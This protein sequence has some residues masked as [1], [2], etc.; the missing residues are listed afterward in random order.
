[1][2]I[3]AEATKGFTSHPPTH[4]RLKP[5]DFITV[6]KSVPSHTLCT[7]GKDLVRATE[8]FSHVQMQHAWHSVHTCNHHC[9]ITEEKHILGTPAVPGCCPSSAMEARAGC[10]LRGQAISRSGLDCDP[11][12]LPISKRG[13][14]HS[15]KSKF[16]SG[17]AKG[18]ACQDW[19]SSGEGKARDRVAR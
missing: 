3:R 14:S 18:S 10:I 16:S 9:P 12:G 13:D 1:M 17:K 5:P 2:P 8:M 7:A 11:Q 15:G 19:G 4:K 6:Y